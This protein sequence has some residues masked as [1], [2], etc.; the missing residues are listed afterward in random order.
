MRHS[1]AFNELSPQLRVK[2]A[3]VRAIL[4]MRKGRLEEGEAIYEDLVAR[5]EET[6]APILRASLLNNLAVARLEQGRF[7]R[8]AIMLDRCIAIDRAMGAE[9]PQAVFAQMNRGAC[10]LYAGAAN[11][12]QGH[13]EEAARL[14][15]SSGLRGLQ[16]EIGACLGLVS[17]AHGSLTTATAILT[18]LDTQPAYQRWEEERFKAAWLRGFL[19]ARTRPQEAAEYLLEEAETESSFDVP[20][21]HKLRFLATLALAAGTDYENVEVTPASQEARRDLVRLGCGWF[22]RSATRWWQEARLRN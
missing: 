8:A 5:L 18:T 6:A 7:K 21:Y 12:A 1:P 9:V 15:E 11:Q 16:D 22:A 4:A 14:C 2:V 20:S 3:S 17:L 13:Y 10:A 19:M